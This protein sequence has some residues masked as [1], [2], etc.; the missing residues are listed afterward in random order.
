M[1][2]CYFYLIIFLLS[3]WLPAHAQEET[4]EGD[5]IASF[6][7]RIKS[8]V[9]LLKRLK[10]TG[11]IQAQWQMAQQPGIESFAGGNFPANVDNR[12]SV[13]RGRVK[14]TYEWDFS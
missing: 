3:L 2:Q 10:I 8:D 9:D 6:V 5:T 14:F 4:K 13:R 11:Y 1:K 12:F 7:D